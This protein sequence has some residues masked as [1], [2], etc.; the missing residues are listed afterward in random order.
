MAVRASDGSTLWRTPLKRP[1]DPANQFYVGAAPILANGLVFVS[2]ENDLGSE[3]E[4]LRASDG[5]LAW[6]L[7]PKD[8]SLTGVLNLAS[9]QGLVF[10]GSHNGTLIAVRSSDGMPVWSLHPPPH[11]AYF[12]SPFFDD[13]VVYGVGFKQILALRASDGTQLWSYSLLSPESH[14]QLGIGASSLYVEQ[15]EHNA[16]YLYSLSAQTGQMRWK[17]Q[18]G[19]TSLSNV[20]E[21]GDLVYVASDC[22][23][24]AL[25]VSDGQ[26]AWQDNAGGKAT[27][28]T[29]LLVNDVLFVSSVVV[30]GHLP[31]C[32]QLYDSLTAVNAFNPTTGA[33]YW[34]SV[35]P[36]LDESAPLIVSDSSPGG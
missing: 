9:G 5:A 24:D 20:S 25:R 15:V 19:F 17:Y 13:G 23:L 6:S 1:A 32:P 27:F 22:S 35:W 11:E 36:S 33:L 3:V 10:V 8:G 28:G 21:A 16:K 7:S 12:I 2:F 14:P 29:P 34:R 31:A 18:I 4:A 30:S 26:L